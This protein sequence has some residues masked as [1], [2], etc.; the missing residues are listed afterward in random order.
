MLNELINTFKLIIVF[1]WSWDLCRF[2]DISEKLIDTTMWTISKLLIFTVLS[3]DFECCYCQDYPVGFCQIQMYYDGHSDTAETIEQISIS[4]KCLYCMHQATYSDIMAQATGMGFYE[5]VSHILLILSNI[6]PTR[7]V[8][9]TRINKIQPW[10][11]TNRFISSLLME[12]WHTTLSLVQTRNVCIKTT[13]MAIH[14]WS[15]G[16]YIQ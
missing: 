13:Y 15:G 11:T 14:K 16:L 8:Y 12:I 7:N 3:M 2:G 10:K 9:T 1:T 6:Q 5:N 4:T